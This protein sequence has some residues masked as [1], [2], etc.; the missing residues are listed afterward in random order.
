M[1]RRSFIAGAVAMPAVISGATRAFGQAEH[2]FRLHHLLGAKAPAQTKMLE[3]WARQVEENSGGRVKID[4]YPAMTLGGRPPELV[5]QARD[6]VVD[7]IWTVNGY[8]PGQFPRTEVMELPTVYVN[9]PVAANLALHD[10][11][12]EELRDEY[13]GL[14]VMFLHVHAGQ[15]IHMRDKLV[16]RP[17]DLQGMKMRIPTRTGAWIIESLGAVPVAMPVPELPSAL[18]KG[19]VDGAFI[20]WEIIPP[21]KIHE[22]T[23]YQIEGYKQERFGTTTFQV[24]MNKGRWNSLPDDIKQA[25][26]DASNRDWWAEVGRIW[27]ASDDFGIK[28]AVDAGNEHIVLT[29]E[30]TQAFRDA[31]QPVVARWVDEVTGKGIDGAG[32]VAKARELV[33]ANTAA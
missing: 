2:V 19:V 8:T 27:R 13:K 17:E 6:G 24:S 9:D 10:M 30:E 32:L 5:Q 28:V 23:K 12:E 11:F 22:Q 1:K 29:E 16:R 33:S 4:I 31:M 25:F 20:P 18:Q 15:G 26:R 21:L 7:I 14:E 3:P